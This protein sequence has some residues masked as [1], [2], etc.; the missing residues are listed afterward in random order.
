LGR[1][2]GEKRKGAEQIQEKKCGRGKEKAKKKKRWGKI[3]R[4]STRSLRGGT[5]ANGM[6]GRGKAEKRLVLK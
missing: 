3:T 4:N 5:E 6:S 1:C 2:R